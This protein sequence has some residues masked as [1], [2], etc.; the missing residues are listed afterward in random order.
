MV[1]SDLKCPYCKYLSGKKKLNE[2]IFR[3][4]FVTRLECPSCGQRFNAYEKDGILKFTIPK[5][6]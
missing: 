1:S 3:D 2:W 6:F 4:F 5:T